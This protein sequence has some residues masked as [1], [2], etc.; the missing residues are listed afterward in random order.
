MHQNTVWNNIN[1]LYQTRYIKKKLVL[2]PGQ[3]D[4]KGLLRIYEAAL[5]DE[6]DYWLFIGKNR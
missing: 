4:E 3:W 1:Q 6:H 2:L 5:D